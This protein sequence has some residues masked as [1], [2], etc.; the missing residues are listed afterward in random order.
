MVIPSLGFEFCPEFGNWGG[1]LY[2]IADRFLAKLG[3]TTV[4]VQAKLG[5]LHDA[6]PADEGFEHGFFASFGAGTALVTPHGT[7]LPGVTANVGLAGEGW[8]LSPT[9]LFSVPF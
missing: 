5:V 3:N 9:L 8:S 1:T 6:L 2:V 4:T 7:W